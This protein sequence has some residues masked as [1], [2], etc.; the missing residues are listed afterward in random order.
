MI[1]VIEEI[2][3][4]I[5]ICLFTQVQMRKDRNKTFA[6]KCLKKR[7]IV[8]TRQQEHVYS[9]KKILLYCSSPFIVR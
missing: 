4:L 6:L 7:H 3:G 8:D 5:I 9:E 2:V 1:T